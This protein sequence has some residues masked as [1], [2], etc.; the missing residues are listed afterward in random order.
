VIQN[1]I[2][3]KNGTLGFNYSIKNKNKEEKE[4]IL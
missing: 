1:K 3:R 4:N 2:E